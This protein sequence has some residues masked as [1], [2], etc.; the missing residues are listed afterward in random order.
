MKLIY[1]SDLGQVVVAAAWPVV[2]I[3][4]K[5]LT[6]ISRITSEFLTGTDGLHRH[7]S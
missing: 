7:I 1:L 4:E 2:Y 3:L 5:L 6:K